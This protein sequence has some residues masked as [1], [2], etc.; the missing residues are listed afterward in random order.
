MDLVEKLKSHLITNNLIKKGDCI[1]LAVSGGLDSVALLHLFSKIQDFFQLKLAVVHVNH[2]IRGEEADG[3]LE[4]VRS[5][6]DQYNLPFYFQKV[7]ALKFAREQRYSLEESARILRYQVYEET[8]KKSKFAKLATG[9]TANDQAETILQHLLRGSGILGMSGIAETRGPYIRPLLIFTRNELKTYVK[10]HE[11]QYRQDSTNRELKYR[12]NRI[13][14]ELIPYLEK[15]FNPNLIKTLNHLG[16][17]FAENEQ[18]LKFHAN[19]SFDTLVV[20][21]KKNKIILDI[22]HF[23][24]YFIILRK[25][26]IFRVFEELSINRNLLN[27]DK[28]SK[29]LKLIS[30]KEI[31]KQITFDKDWGLYID[32]DGIVIKKN[33]QPFPKTKLN[34]LEKGPVRFRDYEFGWTI[35]ERQYLKNFDENPNIEFLDLEQTGSQLYLRNFQ[36]GDRFIP[37]NFTGHKKV[38]DYFSD[39]KIPHHFREEIPILESNRGIV[40]I[41]GYCIDDRFKV[42]SDSKRIL[43]VEMKEVSNA[44]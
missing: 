36:P 30:N 26:I 41:C 3:D 1:L 44:A 10:Q 32:H 34:V 14:N 20:Y 5:L 42:T 2:G 39:R 8:L 19:E 18:F 16:E 21:R 9:H 31:G 29:I 4:F 6:S 12:R 25:Y 38:A 43:K 35:F 28:L 13:R 24:N 40:W 17:I 22:N 7:D 11:L 33:V 15:N 27:F 23:L 37:L